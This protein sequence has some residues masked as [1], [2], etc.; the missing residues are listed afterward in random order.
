VLARGP[1]ARTIGGTVLTDQDRPP[2]A[3]P[4]P[5]PRKSLFQ[6][7]LETLLLTLILFGVARFSLQNFKVDGTS[8]V[9]TLQSGE[10]ILVD[11]ISYRFHLPARGDIIVFK[12]PDDPS[13]DFIKR[14]IGLPG[15]RIAIKLVGGT[16]RTFVN[17]K[18]LAE[19]YINGPMDTAYPQD[20]ASAQT[21]T[22]YVVPPHDLFVMGDNRNYSFDSRSWGPMPLGDIIGRALVSYW[23]LSHLALLPNQYS[24]ASAH[25]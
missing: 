19:P 9:P 21:C 24:Y 23:P 16:Y 11:K 13:R 25:K 20:C 14:V 8:M 22:P 2:A 7:L 15:D 12:Y 6:E 3:T 5:K 1:A 4:S 18:M 17:G 10:Y